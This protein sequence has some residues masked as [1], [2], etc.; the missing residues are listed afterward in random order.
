MS[1]MVEGKTLHRSESK[2]EDWHK[3]FDKISILL[4]N[5]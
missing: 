5:T 3:I 4:S 1:E 2:S